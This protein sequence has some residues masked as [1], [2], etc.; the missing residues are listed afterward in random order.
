[1]D[2]LVVKINSTVEEKVMGD[3]LIQ[4]LCDVH[5]NLRL[6]GLGGRV[7]AQILEF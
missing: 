1:M 6:P 2:G 4:S 5:E 7:E 3:I